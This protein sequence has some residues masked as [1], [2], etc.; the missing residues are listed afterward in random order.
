MDSNADI[1]HFNKLADRTDSAI[2][3]T[4]SSTKDDIAGLDLSAFKNN[5]LDITITGAPF[6]G[7]TVNQSGDQTDLL[8]LNDLVETSTGKVTAS[9][10]GSKTELSNLSSNTD[11]NITITIDANPSMT[12]NELTLVDKPLAILLPLYLVI[13]T[14]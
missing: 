9:I 13:L 6:D 4:I 5:D 3:A 2:S 8:L 7:S 12:V 11:D 14:N 10:T 1:G